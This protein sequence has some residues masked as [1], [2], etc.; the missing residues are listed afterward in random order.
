MYSEQSDSASAS[1]V[2]VQQVPVTHT[3]LSSNSLQV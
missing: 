3:L 2:E 1:L